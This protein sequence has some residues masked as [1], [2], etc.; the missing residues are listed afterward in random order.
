MKAAYTLT[1][2]LR[3]FLKE[4]FG[5]LIEG[6][7]QETMGKLRDMIEKEKPPRIISVGDIVSQNLHAC[8]IHPQ[9]TVIDYVS[10]RNQVMPKQA[11]VEKTVYV[12]NPQGTITEEAISAIKEALK[13]DVHTHVV[14]DGEEDLLT[15]I[16]VLYAPENSFVVYGQPYVGIVVVKASVEK[17][18]QVKGFLNEMKTSKS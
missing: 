7:P 4:P 12:K 17:K 16:A 15:L 8:S 2:R 1:P 11:P 3:V 5:T 13:A 14:V 10:L 6:S 9:L 18:A